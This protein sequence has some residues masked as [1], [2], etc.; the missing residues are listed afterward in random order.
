MRIWGK[1][2]CVLFIVSLL[3]LDAGQIVLAENKETS[4]G[5]P[6]TLS[7]WEYHWGQ[8]PIDDKGRLIWE[9]SEEYAY[10]GIINDLWISSIITLNPPHRGARNVI[11]YRVKLPPTQWSDPSLIIQVHG[12]FRIYSQEEL[13]YEFGDFDRTGTP[14][15]G[16][17][18]R[19]VQLPPESMG[20]LLY[21]EIH[22]ES[23]NIG[24]ATYPSI[25]SRSEIILTLLKYQ[26]DKI[27]IG[28]FYI[29]AG[30]ISL[31]PYYRMRMKPFFSFGLFGI[32]LGIYT[33]C[34]TTIINF[35]YDAP[36]LWASVE[37]TALICGMASV[38][39]FLVQLFGEN[40]PQDRALQM[41][42]RV[43]LL[44]AIIVLPTIFLEFLVLDEV[45]LY[46]RL[47]MLASLLA[48]NVYLAV[49][50]YRKNK[51][52]QIVLLGTI[53]FSLMGLI[54]FFNHLIPERHGLFSIS[55]IGML[56]FLLCLIG[57][58]IRRSVNMLVRLRNSEKLSLV[59]QLA[60]GIAHEIRNPL[61]VISGNLQLMQK[62]GHNED[63]N[64][65]ILG[66]INRINSILN[67]FLYLAKPNQLKLEPNNINDIMKDVVSL[68]QAQAMS[69]P[70]QFSVSVP[71]HAGIVTCDP[72]QL[73]KVFVN[74]LRNAME[75][76]PKG[77][78]ID[79][80]LQRN[81]RNL[82]I[83]FKDEGTGIPPDVLN[84]LSEPFFTTKEGGTGLGLAISRKIIEE[85][86]GQLI[87][88]S[89]E[90]KGTTVS[91]SLPLT[92]KLLI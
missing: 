58:L 55:Y 62:R 51:D 28:C 33:I 91:I 21:L 71:H 6:V 45:L 38:I 83:Q 44:F 40:R 41:L 3:A 86:K 64:Q 74:I 65:L 24:L 34:R 22:S 23:K 78:K 61:T 32:F 70:I 90:S 80:S 14:Y 76:M 52:A 20:K 68:F 11:W 29:L 39:A 9:R 53:C 57:V 92:R 1:T 36:F 42:W 48:V 16:N 18:S 19:I 72:N 31:Y 15:Q 13:I 82:T 54:D 50:A 12:K 30:L 17:T 56:I 89:E 27:I 49:M 75:A 47:F 84:R 8:F 37:L 43:H 46:Y 87:L 2:L 10:E 79:V 25:A 60:A 26:V 66:E 73:K 67:E 77:G 5:S 88:E 35:F 63:R 81:K 85:H 59:G 4:V 7:N 69:P